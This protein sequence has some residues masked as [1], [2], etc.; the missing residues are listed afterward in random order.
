MTELRDLRK[1]KADSEKQE[2]VDIDPDAVG[3]QLQ[4]EMQKMNNAIKHAVERIKQIQEQARSKNSGVRL[5]VNEKIL[6]HCNDLMSAVYVLV[7][8]ARDLQ[9]EIVDA[10]KGSGSPSEFYKKNHQW[11]KGLLSAA[12]AVGVSAVELM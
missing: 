5:E 11:T 7:E 4:D 3:A 12:Q 10:G 9:Q 2:D 8:R 6:E 1:F